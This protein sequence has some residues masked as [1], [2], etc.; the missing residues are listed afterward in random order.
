M[1]H[2]ITRH[3]A[4][5]CALM[6][7]AAAPA[8]AG[9]PYAAI[10]DAILTNNADLASQAAAMRAEYQAAKADNALPATEVE[11][12][13]SYAHNGTPGSDRWSLSVSQG[14][15]WPGVYKARNAAAEAQ[16]DA[17]SAMQRSRVLDKALEARLL[18]EDWAYAQQRL[19]LLQSIA[20]NIDSLSAA[21]TRAFDMG[22][23]SI[24]DV[25]KLKLQSLLLSNDIAEAGADIDAAR[26]ALIALNGGMTLDLDA[27]GIIAAAADDTPQPLAA[28][29]AYLDAFYQH[30][31]M[32]QSQAAALTAAQHRLSAAK[33]S[34]LPGLSLGYVHNYEDGTHFNGFSVGLTLPLWG[35]NRRRAAASA[36]IESISAGASS[37]E[38]T[39]RADIIATYARARSLQRRLSSYAQ[40]L[41][42][43]EYQR[44]LR[45]ALAGGQISVMQYI[46]EVNYL[47]DNTRT[48]LSLRYDYALALARL[49]R[50]SLEPAR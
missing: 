3:I 32:L 49:N 36:D 30:D 41:G 6:C 33:A 46:N 50:F 18:L 44:L 29:D 42:D 17:L 20:A 16:A 24:L 47:I 28:E 10:I 39:T 45:V 7:A 9:D 19:A 26:A 34:A 12:E 38:M 5:I 14:F 31:P 8:Y 23:A 27:A 25:K 22:E 11:F 2:S 43:A 13:R 4:L 35:A 15:E 48:Y 37:Y 1:R 40:V 21:T